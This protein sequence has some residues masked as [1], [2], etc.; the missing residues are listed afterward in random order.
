MSVISLNDVKGAI[1]IAWK[2]WDKREAKSFRYKLESDES[3]NIIG[4]QKGGMLNYGIANIYPMDKSSIPALKTWWEDNESKRYG[5]Q[6]V[7]KSRQKKFREVY[8][9]NAFY[10]DAMPFN[11]HVPTT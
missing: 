3:I 9:V 2:M 1:S 11:F 4:E 6:G 8:A 5:K 7:L 10:D